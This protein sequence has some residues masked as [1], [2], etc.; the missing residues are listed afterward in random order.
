MDDGASP[1]PVDAP[2]EYR[3][4]LLGHLGDDDPVVVQGETTGAIRRLIEDAGPVVTVRP[5]PREW[6]VLECIGHIGDAELVVS[7][8]Y[9]WIVAHDEP[10]LIGYDQDRWVDRLRHADVDPDEIADTFEILRRGN[11]ALWS[12]SSPEDRVRVGIHAERGRRALRP[13]ST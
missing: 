10:P 12:R 11:L 1:D 4:F 2:A 9:R 7:G 6:S 3:A 8:R 5:A 13:R